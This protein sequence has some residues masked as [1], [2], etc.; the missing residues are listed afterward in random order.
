M[1]TQFNVSWED[2]NAGQKE[3]VPYYKL[4]DGTNIIR[5]AS[6]PSVINVHWEETVDGGSRRCV[7]GGAGCPLC[8]AGRI[9]S[10]RYQMK[11]LAKEGD[12]FK[13]YILEC[14]AT[15]INAIKSF[16]LDPEFGNPTKYNI[17]INKS[18]TGMDTKY[19]CIPSSKKSDLTPEQ[20]EMV[21][22]L[23]NIEEINKILTDEELEN[24]NLLCLAS[25]GLE[26]TTSADDWDI[27]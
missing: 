22:S 25:T 15:I 9:Y 18:G 6:D 27:V 21:N 13:P 1:A 10:K 26:T 2:L 5:V 24:L 8:K 19:S 16:A 20:I 23:P 14:G 7:C 3:E 12:E 4:K 11:I 17:K